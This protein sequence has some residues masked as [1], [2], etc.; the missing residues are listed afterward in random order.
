MVQNG[1]KAKTRNVF[2]LGSFADK[3]MEKEYENGEPRQLMRD[4]LL[5]LLVY[6]GLSGSICALVKSASEIVWN[7]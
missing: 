7:S 4:F 3:M 5:G 2:S 6:R 1:W